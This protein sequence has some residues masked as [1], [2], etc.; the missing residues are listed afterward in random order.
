MRGSLSEGVNFK[1]QECTSL[2]IFGLPF[3]L[4]VDPTVILKMKYLNQKYNEIEKIE[5]KSSNI[6]GKN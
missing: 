1:N 3:A 6:I 5:F 2:F 4:F